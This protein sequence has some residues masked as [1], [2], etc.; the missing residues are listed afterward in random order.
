MPAG[1]AL[2]AL[3]LVVG[4]DTG[5]G[6]DPE[7]EPEAAPEGVPEPDAGCYTFEEHITP[8]FEARRCNDKFCHGQA[9]SAE[10]GTLS[11]EDLLEGG[12]SGP[13]ITACVAESSLLYEKCTAPP[14]F[15][16]QMPTLGPKLSAEELG[17]LAAWI[18]QGLDACECP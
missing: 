3:G 6:P 16:N 13:S 12:E 10:L 9:K 8:L 2:L 11:V 14:P 18:D 17:I 4:C 5:P 1:V 15:G 7:P